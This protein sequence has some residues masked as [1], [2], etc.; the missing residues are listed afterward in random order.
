V[1]T[2]L[3]LLGRIVPALRISFGPERAARLPGT[4]GR[5]VL[6]GACA[7]LAVALAVTLV[8]ADGSWHGFGDFGP[9]GFGDD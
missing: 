2:G 3:H 6:V 9:G 5:A 8:H 7:V 4:W 1:A